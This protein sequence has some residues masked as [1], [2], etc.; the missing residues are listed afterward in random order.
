MHSRRILQLPLR[1]H[2]PRVH[3]TSQFPLAPRYPIRNVS[4]AA[5]HT[6]SARRSRW[7]RR[8]IYLGIFGALG[9]SVGQ[10]MDKK[11]SAP[12]APGTPE[13]KL[14]LQDIQQVFDV[15]LPIV[16]RLRRDPDYVEMGV[17]Q[18]YSE[19]SKANRL[20]SGP[21]AGSRG[22]GLQKVFWNEKEHQLVSVV[23]MGSGIEGWPTMVHGGALGTIIDEN[24][25][26]AAIRHFPAQTGV[27]ANLNINYRAPVYSDSF[28][29][30]HTTLDPERSTDRKAYVTCELRDMTGRV[31]VEATGL[32]VVPKK[33]KLAKLGD[34]F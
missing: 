21:L 8:F 3:T 34:H 11:I 22:F 26:R 33:L 4:T 27:T 7:T 14:Q 16:Q 18:N 24:L 5:S 29:S 12:P 2:A 19:K 28:W 13:D 6:T 25:G 31:C 23:F 15:G 32:F 30:L 1:A 17:Y 10:W 20:T 9:I